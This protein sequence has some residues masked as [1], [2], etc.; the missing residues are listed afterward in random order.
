M[1]LVEVVMMTKEEGGGGVGGVRRLI[2]VL[3]KGEMRKRRKDSEGGDGR[4][5]NETARSREINTR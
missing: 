3:P 2:D 1:I 5:G 4:W